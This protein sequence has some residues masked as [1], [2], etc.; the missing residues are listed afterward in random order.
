MKKWSGSMI[1]QLEALVD[2]EAE[3]DADADPNVYAHADPK[4][5]QRIDTL[6]A[7]VV[8]RRSGAW[9]SRLGL[10]RGFEEG[11]A[12]LNNGNA[13]TL[14]QPYTSPMQHF[15]KPSPSHPVSGGGVSARPAAA[16]KGSGKGGAHVEGLPRGV[17]TRGGSGLRRSSF[18]AT[19]TDAA[20]TSI[21]TTLTLGAGGTC[22]APRC[23]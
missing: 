20:A 11:S 2:V 19:T 22:A 12:F 18:I 21:A 15:A 3:A 5:L 7:S 4:Q 6:K 13:I 8:R 10:P 14:S 23:Q 16:D 9:G 1:A 17:S